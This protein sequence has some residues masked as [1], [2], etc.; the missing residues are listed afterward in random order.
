[1]ENKNVK[2]PEKYPEVI[3]KLPKAVINVKGV[4]ARILQGECQQLVFFDME[5]NTHLPE[6]SHD[7]PQWGIMLRGRMNLTI[8][9]E[10]YLINKGD[11]YVIP[12]NA[13]HYAVFLCRSR[14]IDLFSERA[15]YSCKP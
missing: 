14:V 7:Y 6:H 10:T 1:M 4:E 13:K 12:A 5:A 3:T 8:G 15:R 2:N 11:E 9:G